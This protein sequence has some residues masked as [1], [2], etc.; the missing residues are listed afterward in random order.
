MA[1]NLVRN[2]KLY[3]TT[4]F[5]T[6]GANT[7]KVVVG[8]DT[9]AHTA[10]TTFEI[11]VLDGFSFSQT[12][13]SETVTISESGST[14]VRGQRSFNTSLAPVEFSF[15]TYIR[16]SKGA[17][18][19]N[20]LAEEAV[21]WNALTSNA[22][23]GATPNPTTGV[24]PGWTAG[25]VNTG[26]NFGNGSKVDLTYSQANQLQKFGLIFTIDNVTYII[27]NCVM[28]QVTIDFGLDGIATAAWSGSGASIT[29]LSNAVK[30]GATAGT[31]QGGIAGSSAYKVKDDSASF[32]A[33]KLSTC[34]ITGGG[35]TYK[36]P[37]T[38]GSL[39]FNNNITFLTPSNL[40]IVN[41]PITYFTGVRSITGTI[42]AYLKTGASDDTGSLLANM[43]SDT[44]NTSPKFNL[45]INIGG[46]SATSPRVR[47]SMPTTVLT[48]PS[49]DV[50]QVVSTAINFTA[51]S[52]SDGTASGT[53]DITKSNEL[54]VTYF[55]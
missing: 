42:N 50:Q 21:L 14:P 24:G 19:T 30:P 40:G 41:T 5:Y 29:T 27:E 35:T 36:V 26:G 39:T 48:L 22:A 18:P 44:G 13:N 38:G 20:V 45:E 10:S 7:G 32:I 25:T 33:N 37:L 11:Q 9:P 1:L 17:T 49:V 46:E 31:F 54:T 28:N 34:S 2:S 53:Y 23:I 6:T 15:S 4:N 12:T 55:I 51:Q 47:L 3:F 8:S 43:L 16:P 52:S